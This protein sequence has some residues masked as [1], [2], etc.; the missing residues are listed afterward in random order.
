[1]PMFDWNGTTGTE[2][3]KAYDYDGTTS[4]QLDKGYDWDGTSSHLLFSS[5]LNLMASPTTTWN[6]RTLKNPLS[7]A[8]GYASATVAATYLRGETINGSD[9]TAVCLTK[10]AISFSGYSKLKITG[11]FYGDTLQGSGYTTRARCTFGCSTNANASV[12]MDELTGITGFNDTFSG[13]RIFFDTAPRMNGTY[14]YDISNLN[15]SYYIKI[16]AIRGG[17]APSA[18][19]NVTGMVLE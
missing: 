19:F 5:E 8:T 9:V 12:A 1:M 10:S 4:H 2:L 18:Y 6:A 11:T 3:G 13:G 14:T 16:L 7:G 17:L 15:G